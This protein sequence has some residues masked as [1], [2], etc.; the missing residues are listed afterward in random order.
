[1]SA[2]TRGQEVRDKNEGPNSVENGGGQSR[3]CGRSVRRGRE[4][5]IDVRA[6]RKRVVLLVSD[7]RW[8][9]S[10]IQ[11]RLLSAPR[12]PRVSLL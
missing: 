4:R 11:M 6:A 10:I 12:K 8:M 5:G 3:R 9:E 7:R 2:D 1:M